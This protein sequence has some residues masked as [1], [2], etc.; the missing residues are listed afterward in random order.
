M[1]DA[2]RYLLT[3]WA[4]CLAHPE[5]VVPILV[6]VV[7]NVVPRTPPRNRQLFALWSVVERACVLGWAKWGGPW[8][9]LGIVSPNP[10]EWAKAEVAQFAAREAPT[11][12]DTPTQPPRAA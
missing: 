9:L 1:S 7:Y 10:T 12:P 11:K 6:Y 2:Q 4:W 5:I 3:A 8:K